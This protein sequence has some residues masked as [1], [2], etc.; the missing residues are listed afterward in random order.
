M[1]LTNVLTLIWAFI[2]CKRSPWQSDSVFEM[3]THIIVRERAVFFG[4][5]RTA[6]ISTRWAWSTI[7]QITQNS[8]LGRQLHPATMGR[9]PAL[10]W[11]R[12]LDQELLLPGQHDRVDDHGSA[13][14]VGQKKGLKLVTID[15]TDLRTGIFWRLIRSCSMLFSFSIVMCFNEH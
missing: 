6:L 1:K 11:I 5:C 10:N 8:F 14:Q 12:Q 7:L 9:N 13:R 15:A 2:L 3:R 4:F